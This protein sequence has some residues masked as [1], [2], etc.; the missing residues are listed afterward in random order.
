MI[1]WGEKKITSLSKKGAPPGGK[2]EGWVPS[3]RKKGFKKKSVGCHSVKKGTEGK[4]K[5]IGRGERA[6]LEL[7]EVER[8]SKETKNLKDGKRW[9]RLN[10]EKPF[11]GKKTLT[12]WEKRWEKFFLGMGSGKQRILSGGG[13]EPEKRKKHQQKKFA[14]TGGKRKLTRK[15][16]VW[17]NRV[18]GTGGKGKRGWSRGGQ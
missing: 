17:P 3:E 13:G 14:K 5:D 11:W 7:Q 1:H 12:M 6:L 4:T 9:Q 10:I 8:K 16:A 15:N 18:G 2:K